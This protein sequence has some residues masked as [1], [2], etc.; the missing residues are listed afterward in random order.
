MKSWYY[1]DNGQLCGPFQD[2]EKGF[3]KDA[4]LTPDTLVW[5]NGPGDVER[6]WV[7]AAETELFALFNDHERLVSQTPP[8]VYSSNFYEYKSRQRQFELE[9]AAQ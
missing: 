1:T 8:P 5:N 4:L 3:I 2:N 6:G 7:R 9:A